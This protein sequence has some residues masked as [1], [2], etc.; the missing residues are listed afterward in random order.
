MQPQ[1]AQRLDGARRLDRAHVLRVPAELI[2]DRGD[3]LLRARDT[4]EIITGLLYIGRETEGLHETLNTPTR[5]L[6]ELTEADL[7]QGSNALEAINAS[8]R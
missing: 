1:H 8:L 5:P 7:C 4:G 6:N 3:G 2:A